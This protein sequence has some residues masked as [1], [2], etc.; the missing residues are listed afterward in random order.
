MLDDAHKKRMYCITD[1]GT[2]SVSPHSSQ[3]DNGANSAVELERLLKV[4]EVAMKNFSEAAIR[5]GE[6]MAT[7]DGLFDGARATRW[8]SFMRET[9]RVPAWMK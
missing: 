7:L 8:W 3:W 2:G 4:R 1:S 5:P 9:R 6:P